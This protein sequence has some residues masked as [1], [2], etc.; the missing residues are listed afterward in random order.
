MI[1]RGSAVCALLAIIG[2][3]FAALPVPLGA[4][5]EELAPPASP[6]NRPPS[7]GYTLHCSGCHR[8][9]GS[10]IP[11]LAPTLRDLAPLADTPKGRAYLIGVP[12]VAQ[13]PVRDDE[14]AALMNWVIERFSG[15]PPSNRFDAD[16]VRRLRAD[17][18][19][20]PVVAR[21]ALMGSVRDQ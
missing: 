21:A 9:D 7:E 15:R 13:A 10:G 20:D 16:E 1:G 4:H 17:P 19:R 12:G 5:A 14:L 8:A 6:T 2:V 18:I 11:D 3:V